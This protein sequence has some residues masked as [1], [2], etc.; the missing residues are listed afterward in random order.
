[1]S[2]NIGSGTVIS[3]NSSIIKVQF[4]N[5][6]P[7][8]RACLLLEKNNK[9]FRFEVTEHISDEIVQAVAMDLNIGI[10][11]GDIISWE[12]DVP[13]IPT[14]VVGRVVNYAGDPL[15]GKPFV[16]ANKV[17][18]FSDTPDFDQISTKRSFLETGIKVIDFFAPVARGSKIGLFGSAGVGKTVLVSELI[19]NVAIKHDGY[20]VFVG[21]GE[22]NREGLELYEAMQSNGILCEKDPRLA[23]LLSPMASCAGQ[24]S[25]VVYSGLSVA[26]YYAK[27][28]DVLLLIDNVFRYTQASAE[29][30]TL[31]GKIPA[32][33]GY[34][35]DLCNH[36]GN[37]QDRIVS[38][39]NGSITSVQAVYV[40]AEDFSDP[41]VDNLIKHF[42]SSIVLDRTIAAKGIYPAINPLLSGSSNLVSDIVGERH[43]NLAKQVK[44]IL[45][46]YYELSQF[47]ET[48]GFDSLDDAQKVV[49]SRA[50]KL[51]LFFSQPMFTAAKFTNYKGKYVPIKEVL[52]VVEAILSGEYDDT[53]K[54]SFRMKG[55]KIHE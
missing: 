3:V 34:P 12:S 46:Q 28:K 17:S 37:I 33:M 20:S 48:F 45:Q 53:S 27:Q 1:M 49:V 19:H 32:E 39:K 25:R 55:Y 43:V 11:R 47:L 13:L 41:A 16:A 6:V 31:E 8:I 29:L 22:R 54:E 5:G 38:T 23:I 9:S 10:S 7:A 40:P 42:N 35:A 36:I 4:M 18:I 50:Q 24:R 14:N 21:S 26:E 52:N 44:S 51:E 15:D 30:A 2:K